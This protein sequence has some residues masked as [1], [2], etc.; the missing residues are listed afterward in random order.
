MNPNL[1][2]IEEEEETVDLTSEYHHIPPSSLNECPRCKIDPNAH[3]FEQKSSING[4]TVFYTCPAKATH[5]NDRDGILEH[6]EITL[7]NHGDLP[8]IFEI[9]GQG[10]G[11][12]HAMEVQLIIGLMRVISQTYGKNL[13]QINIL[14]PT[15][16][17]H[18]ILM[19]IWPFLDDNIRA[20]VR[21]CE[22]DFDV[23]LN[24]FF[25]T[26]KPKP[27]LRA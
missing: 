12:K 23:E 17:F 16:T 27:L 25:P 14:H 19:V 21:I 11:I 2:R 26:T 7:A 24:E 8:W 18:T 15:V 22:G 1:L 9:D 20:I 6:V 3:S 13:L 10:F 4:V 5:Y